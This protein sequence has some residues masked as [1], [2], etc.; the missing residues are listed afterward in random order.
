MDIFQLL[1]LLIYLYLGVGVIFAV[2]FVFKGVNQVDPL[3][4]EASLATRLILIP[5]SAG[6]WVVLLIKWL[7]T[8]NHG[9]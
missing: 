5:G 6:L 9:S 7:K 3:M 4:H 1:V 2:W 8:Q